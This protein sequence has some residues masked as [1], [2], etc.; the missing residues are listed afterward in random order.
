MTATPVT[1][2]VVK[3]RELLRRDKVRSMGDIRGLYVETRK[4]ERTAPDA[5]SEEARVKKTSDTKHDP[6]DK[7]A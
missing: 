1:M 7:I 3:L 4:K 2:M 6:L 5:V